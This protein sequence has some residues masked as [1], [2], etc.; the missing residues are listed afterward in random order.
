VI[1]KAFVAVILSKTGAGRGMRGQLANEDALRQ[2]NFQGGKRVM[3]QLDGVNLYYIFSDLVTLFLFK[4]LANSWAKPSFPFA[5]NMVDNTA[6]V[7][8]HIAP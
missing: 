6:I 2:G 3:I 4:L 7:I 8:S 5:C 1:F